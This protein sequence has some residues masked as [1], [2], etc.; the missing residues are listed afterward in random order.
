[1]VSPSELLGLSDLILFLAVIIGAY[2]IFGSLS[3]YLKIKERE[4]SLDKKSEILSKEYTVNGKTFNPSD[5][6]AVF[7]R[8]YRSDSRDYKN[9]L[10]SDTLFFTK[11]GGYVLFLIDSV[12][13]IEIKI[14]T[15]KEAKEFLIDRNRA[16]Y[17]AHFGEPEKI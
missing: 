5:S 7:D 15:E 16:S 8:V 4:F 11:N 13:N 6:D 9:G 14:I 1:M 17:V 12:S 2:A 10:R 3:V